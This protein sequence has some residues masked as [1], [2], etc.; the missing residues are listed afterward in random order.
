MVEKIDVENF[1]KL[2]DE[3]PVVDVRSPAE[4]AQGH[5]PKAINLPLFNNEERAVVGKLY[6][7]SGRETS[8]LKG[9]DIVGP[10][11]SGF[12]KQANKIAPGRKLLMHCWRGGMRSESMAWLL[13]TAG[14]QVHLLTDGYKAYR[15]FIRE[16]LEAASNFIILSGKTGSGKT[17]ILLQMKT[18]GVQVIDL[19]GLANHKGSAFGA[20][21][22]DPQPTNEQFENNLYRVCSGLDPEKTIFLEDESRS[23]GKVVLP[24]GFFQKMRDCPV[25]RLEMGEKLRVERLVVDYAKY[26]KKQ[27]IESV[28]KIEKRIGGQHA[29]KITA[30]IEAEDFYTA[31]QM[32]LGYYDKTYNYG[33]TKRENPKIYHLETNTLNARQN[34]GLVIDYFNSLGGL[35]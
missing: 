12:V 4:F 13:S 16:K 31:I 11:M 9:L 20:L 27:L 17:D 35:G 1:L 7:N 26:P 34:A 15:K 23:I 25:I 6:K 21:G 5:I 2:A 24:E 32:V 29:K 28:N 3:L 30:A 10:K 8:V 18:M 33:L 19:E 14:F 22:E